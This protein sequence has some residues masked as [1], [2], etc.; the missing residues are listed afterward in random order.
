M[1]DKTPH[2]IN[3]EISPI[4]IIAAAGYKEFFFLNALDNRHKLMFYRARLRNF[5][6]KQ[7]P[8]LTQPRLKILLL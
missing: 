8:K 6:Q 7:E 1:V 2:M 3:V 4:F 5:D